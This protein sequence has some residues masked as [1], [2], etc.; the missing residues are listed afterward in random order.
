MAVHLKYNRLGGGGGTAV[1]YQLA[2]PACSVGHLTGV[3][4]MDLL[5]GKSKSQ[6]F[7]GLGAIFTC[8]L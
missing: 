3:C 2:V 1:I 4:W 5:D 8:L 6:L 7:Q